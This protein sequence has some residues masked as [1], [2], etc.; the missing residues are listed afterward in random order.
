MS[1]KSNQVHILLENIDGV[2]AN[3]VIYFDGLSDGQ[4]LALGAAGSILTSAG[5]SAAPV[6]TRDL[7]IDSLVTTG[8]VTIGGSLTVT[9]TVVD[10]ADRVIHLNNST[11]A[12][13][14]VPSAIVGFSVH[15]GAIS[16]VPRD[17]YG[18]FWDEPTSLW[19]F[20]VNTGSD[21]ATLGAYLSVRMLDLTAVAGNFS[22]ALTSATLSPGSIVYA[23]TA[24]L[25]VTALGFTATLPNAL[26]PAGFTSVSTSYMTFAGTNSDSANFDLISFGGGVT[27]NSTFAGY[28]CQGTAASPAATGISDAT[29]L[30]LRGHDGTS[31]VTTTR[32]N[33]TCFAV[34]AWTP[35]S[36]EAAVSISTTPS[37]STIPVVGFTLSSANVA[38][39]TSTVAATGL[40]LSG[41]GTNQNIIYSGAAGVLTTAAGFVVSG[42][43]STVAPSSA[44]NGPATLVGGTIIKQ[45]AD[46]ANSLHVIVA[47]RSGTLGTHGLIGYACQG[48]AASPGATILDD[49]VGLLLR[50]HDGTDFTLTQGQIDIRAGSTWTP[51]SRE[52]LIVFNTTTSGSTSSVNRAA[53]TGGGQLLVGTAVTAPV[54]TFAS[55]TVTPAVQVLGLNGTL[56]SIAQATYAAATSGPTLYLAK[57][58]GTVVGTPGVITTGDFIG[59][60][61]FQGD[62]GT[63]FIEAA[64]IAAQS[65]GTIATGQVPGR[66]RFLTHNASGTNT[67]AAFIDSSQVLALTN[68]TA[69][70]SS[71]VTTGTI[72]PK[73][74]IVGISTSSASLLCGQYNSNATGPSIFLT[75]SRSVTPLTGM[76]IVNTGDAL[77]TLDWQGADGTNFISAARIIVTATGTP[78]T[79]VMPGNM[80]FQTA[81]DITGTLTTALTINNAQAASFASTVTANG[82]FRG[83]TASTFGASSNVPLA[84][85]NGGASTPYVQS[86][87]TTSNT[88]IAVARYDS[89]AT[90]VGSIIIAK[91][92]SGSV[93]TPGVITTG[94]TLGT[95]FFQGD[96]GTNFISAVAISGLSTGTIATG[97]VPGILR[98]QTA[99][100]AGTLT[101][102]GIIDSTQV[103]VWGTASVSDGTFSAG[104]QRPHV[105]TSATTSNNANMAQVL[106]SNSATGPIQILAKSRGAAANTHVVVTTADQI[107]QLSFQ[108]DDGTNFIEGALIS[109]ACEGT[110]ATGV[111]PGRLRFFTHNSAGTLAQAMAIDSQQ[112]LVLGPQTILGQTLYT[113]GTLTPLVQQ[114]GTTDAAS[115]I[116]ITRGSGN[117]NG[118]KLLFAKSRNSTFATMTVVTTGDTLG[119]ID[120]QGSDGTN[121]VSA[122][123]IVATAT[124]TPS[125]G[126]MPGN[127]AIQTATTGGTL[128]TA[129]TIDNA[130]TV[131]VSTLVV[132]TLVSTF[133]STGSPSLQM[134]STGAAATALGQM[135]FTS[136]AANAPSFIQARSKGTTVGDYTA[137]GVNDALGNNLFQG[138]D[139][140]TMANAANILVSCDGTVSAGIVPGRIQLRTAT[141]AGTLTVALTAD[142]A[143]AVTVNTGIFTVSNTTEA[144]AIGTAANV[145]V[146][147]V[148]IAKRLMVNGFA[149]SASRKSTTYLL[150]AADVTTTHDTTSAGYT[151]TLP[152][153]PVNGQIHIIYK[154]VAANTLTIGRNSNNINGAA[155]DISVT[156]AND[157]WQLQFITGY[158]WARL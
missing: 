12:N 40:S 5:T 46:A 94:D 90:T 134:V 120:W 112:V 105:Q 147:G 81:A 15:R 102:A 86:L 50:G 128:T 136:T 20:A 64:S 63:N 107:G 21:D 100:S 72:Q 45:A 106:W 113:T 122:A 157:S 103:L 32:A 29:T 148:S 123:R 55:G 17:H 126:V 22:G 13:D 23:S 152:A 4:S 156:A 42:T 31:W 54:T 115:T 19:K 150:T 139:G 68:S 143:Q 83:V 138:S 149:T 61:S 34:S 43:P 109:A 66:L 127:I 87:G 56:G 53:I 78:A 82:G 117:T 114:L 59:I 39:F 142:S 121:Y 79:G 135:R 18:L 75:K 76:T 141:S 58:R 16:G 101:T 11:G 158:G 98:F 88:S 67:Q 69:A 60:I 7:S 85:F 51:S 131:T 118:G 99:T 154:E 146:G 14:P 111:M 110:I 93:G 25:L 1:I 70:S 73:L 30:G 49:K 132:G 35:T 96:D 104:T 44:T 151:V 91:S 28:V 57:S 130:Q 26:A 80:V 48:T 2:A 65:E 36:T 89:A 10:F 137:V 62:D 84:L 74:Q 119:T 144:S 24:G 108:G 116:A 9:S 153:S 41:L 27:R 47:F 38:T 6:F 125:T 71:F 52:T 124:G 155:A 95:L 3:S 140:T 77:G 8:N 92:R 129:L 37:G 97:Q 145:F 133:A 33:I